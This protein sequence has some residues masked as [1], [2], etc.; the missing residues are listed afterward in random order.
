[1]F[2]VKPLARLLRKRHSIPLL[3]VIFFGLL[4]AK[5]LIGPGYFNMHDDLQMMRQLEMEKCFLDG[6]I[7]CRWVPDMGYGYGFPLFNY[8]PPLPYLIGQGIRLLGFNFVATVKITFALAFVASGVT[9]YFWASRFF[10]RF[11]GIVSS[12]FYLWAPYHAVDIYVRGAMNEAWALVWFPLILLGGFEIL[13]RTKKHTG[14]VLVLAIAWF[15]LL[16]S[17]NLM[18]IVFTPVFALW[19]LGILLYEKKFKALPSLVLSGVIALGLA[20]FF[21]LPVL[22]EKGAV[23]TDTLVRGYYEYTAH[24]SSASQILFSR[25]WGYGPS[26]W[27]AQDDKMSFQV[28]W[29]HWIA[30]TIIAVLLTLRIATKRKVSLAVLAGLFMIGIAWFA[31]FMTHPRSVPIWQLVSSLSF[32]QFPWRFL[33]LSILGFSFGVGAIA[34][35][36][37]RVRSYGFGIL[38]VIAVLVYSWNYFLPEH[39]KMGPLT[40]QQKFSGAAWELQQTAG[41]YDY[42]PTTAKTAPKAPK[43]TVA[44]YVKGEG[45]IPSSQE[46]TNWAQFVTYTESD[47]AVV[48]VNILNFPGWRVFVNGR[49]VPHFVESKDEWGRIAFTVPQGRNE[50]MLRLYN[51]PIRS[52]SNV[53]SMISWIALLG[54]V[55]SKRRSLVLS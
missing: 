47:D 30:P 53:V 35:L 34:H 26:V 17:H 39:G 37:G 19:C 29:I 54:F 55:I 21:T 28:G 46:G 6:Q 16:T 48:R 50:V 5:G 12:V 27:M 2:N 24:F 14:W 51:T 13:S 7:P 11:A 18:V 20:A 36:F 45:S 1:M 42:L 25:Y 10:G 3:I 32:V 38:L 40:D 52:F 4:A 41:I 8:Y 44:E 43:N 23:Q 31:S 33:T 22:V 15:G 9:M 49:E